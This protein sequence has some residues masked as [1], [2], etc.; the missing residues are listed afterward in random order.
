MIVLFITYILI[1]FFLACR[2]PTSFFTFYILI[3][4]KFLGFFDPESIFIIGG[5]GIAT[6]VLN[7]VVLVALILYGKLKNIRGRYKGFSLSILM[8]LL[9]GI[10]SPLLFGYESIVQSLVASKELWSIFFFIYLVVFEEKINISYMTRV[11]VKVGLYI[12]IGY[13]LHYIF[14]LHAPFYYNNGVFRAF[15]PTYIS[16]AW[17]FVCNKKILKE[18]KGL[19]FI[20]YSILFIAGLILAGH[21]ALTLPTILMIT[22][23]FVVLK[24]QTD[25]KVKMFFKSILLLILGAYL[26]F[27]IPN[28]EY[29][30]TAIINN[31]DI[32]LSSRD[33]YNAFRWRAIYEKPFFGY[34]FIHDSAEITNHFKDI[35]NNRFAE[36]FGVIDSGYVDILIKF[37]AVGL[38]FLLYTWLKNIFTVLKKLNKYN[39]LEVLC[40]LY[41]LQYLATTYTWSVFTYNHGLIPG[42]IAI[43]IIINKI[44]FINSRS[45]AYV[46]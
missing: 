7:L 32:A 20:F 22:Y 24:R 40:S 44:E 30:I 23:Y 46:R 3:S 2:K 12:S 34:G 17:F 31:E 45:Y 10:F 28:L 19:H 21:F 18:I 6:P 16:L 11:I 26:V 38:V 42:F 15:Y 39:S 8:L 25:L 1:A 43:F 14:N 4:T 5:L 41:L 27:L 13:I 35:N 9:Y 37:G 36:K 33:I 29:Q